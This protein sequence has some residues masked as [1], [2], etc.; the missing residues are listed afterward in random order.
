[1]SVLHAGL[2]IAGIA[3]IIIPI[4]IHLLFR[5]RRRPIEWAA[6]RYL[7]EAVRRARRRMQLE[8]WILLL[9]RC[10]MILLFALAVARFMF[11]GNSQSTG[12]FA[13]GG[14]VVYLLIDNGITSGL[15]TD[16]E[17]NN[18]LDHH[19]QLAHDIVDSLSQ[20]DRVAV[21]TLAKPIDALVDPPALDHAAVDNLLDEI[22]AMESRSELTS[23]LQQLRSSIDSQSDDTSP[24]I[25]Y[26]LS[27]FL[28][29]QLDVATQA[30]E[31]LGSFDRAVSLYATT[32]A[33]D[34]PSNVQVHDIRPLRALAM[35]NTNDGSGQFRITLHRNGDTTQTSITSV[36][37]SIASAEDD[38]NNAA[39]R[40]IDTKAIAWEA[41]ETERSTDIVLDMHDYEPGQYALIASVDSDPLLADNTQF[42]VF[43]VRNDIR[44]GLAAVQE[45]EQRSEL[46]EFTTGAWFRRAL[47]PGIGSAID[48]VDIDPSVVDPASL[49][50]LDAVVVTRP[51]LV[52]TTGWE[53]LSTFVQSGGL[54]WL[55]PSSTQQVSL[56]TDEAA[57]YLHLPWTWR[58]E[59]V[60]A[61]IA[62]IVLDNEQPTSP[63]LA[64]L[65]GE[66][67]DLLRPIS[68]RQ[69]LPIESGIG[70]EGAVL[71]LQSSVPSIEVDDE[72]T[73]MNSEATT[74]IWMAS[75]VPDGAQGMVVYIASP[76]HLEWTNLPTK[77][78]M[79]ALVQETIRQGLS[80]IKQRHKMYPGETT[81]LASAPSTAYLRRRT[82]RNAN[83]PKTTTNP[84]LNANEI[85]V[86]RRSGVT[87]LDRPAVWTG[88]YDA[89][90]GA[91]RSTGLVAVNVETAAANVSSQTSDRVLAWLEQTGPWAWMDDDNPTASLA[92]SQSQAELSLFL[93]MLVLV[94]AFVETILARRFSHAYQRQTSA[95][96][97]A[98]GGAGSGLGIGPTLGMSSSPNPATGR[99]ST[100]G[101]TT[102]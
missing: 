54:I 86:V 59:A 91:E 37:F 6:M 50:G 40:L 32:P 79:V 84:L 82:L 46:S 63:L 39:A 23:G 11:A 31:I 93:L 27:D 25:V 13:G 49:F 72:G 52:T 70:S 48:V 44:V 26:L 12:L 78:I 64:M 20:S 77:P 87:T 73:S 4:V 94:L 57:Q 75:T 43:E 41:G 18:R 95:G 16:S 10:A 47:N 92:N 45:F 100:G 99:Q 19:I 51:D 21:I 42:S 35:A 36:Q 85:P 34:S 96:V 29:G 24:V 53:A 58:R 33:D 56:W 66:L 68:V 9:L 22:H 1:M 3:A 55:M 74:S 7:L 67:E 8:Q 81:I 90:D 30:S 83:Q 15:Q 69:Y 38:Q 60:D 14:R 71:R 28:A 17:S 97:Y 80:A 5:Q 2:A 98:T 76:P 102:S 65:Q 88:L 62:P 89:I 101:S 61:S